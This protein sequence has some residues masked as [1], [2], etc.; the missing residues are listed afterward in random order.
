[1]NRASTDGRPPL[2]V[3]KAR[4]TSVRDS[5]RRFL[6][7][8]SACT[9]IQYALLVL[10]VDGFG[11]RPVLASG[12]SYAAAVVVN[13]ELSRRWTFAS[14]P[15]RITTVLRFVLV[16]AIGLTLNVALFGAAL[17]L[18]APHYVVAQVFATGVTLL[19]N[20]TLYRTWAFRR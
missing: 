19:V 12:S 4:R 11:W 1:L 2:A 20:F 16:S 6:V 5:F 9:A 14:G 3:R 8:G 17:R 7:V 18:G 13:Y 10:M 15:A